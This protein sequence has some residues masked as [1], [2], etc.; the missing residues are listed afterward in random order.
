[1]AEVLILIFIQVCSFEIV[2]VDSF[3]LLLYVRTMELVFRFGVEN[4]ESD[5]NNLI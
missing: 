2:I 3:L 5:F 1:M 4:F